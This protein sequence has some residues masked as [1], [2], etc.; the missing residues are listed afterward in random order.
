MMPF[1]SDIAAEQAL[2]SY[3]GITPSQAGAMFRRDEQGNTWFKLR[4]DSNEVELFM[5]YYCT[6][7]LELLKKTQDLS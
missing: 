7:H 2:V 1:Y 3:A 5:D 6:F 4:L